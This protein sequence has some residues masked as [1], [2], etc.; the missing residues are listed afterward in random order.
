MDDPEEQVLD[1]DDLLPTFDAANEL[2]EELRKLGEAI[3]IAEWAL[4]FGEFNELTT[5]KLGKHTLLNPRERTRIRVTARRHPLWDPRFCPDFPERV[6]RAGRPGSQ[7]RVQVSMSRSGTRALVDFCS[8][9]SGPT[10]RVS[11][12]HGVTTVTPFME[13]AYRLSA[14]SIR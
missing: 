2:I 8:S 4:R 14:Q 1:L 7:G 9:S 13:T 5:I 10:T 11:S 6:A 12:V 3:E